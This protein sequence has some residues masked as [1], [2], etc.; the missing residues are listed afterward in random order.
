M[1]FQKC[2]RD[3]QIAARSSLTIGCRSARLRLRFSPQSLAAGCGYTSAHISGV[4]QDSQI[5]ITNEDFRGS[6]PIL[7]RAPTPGLAH[8][9]RA[10][11]I[12]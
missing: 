3:Q 9:S 12:L 11:H 2:D 4:Y 8:N 6:E 10:C 1:R 7:R 5:E